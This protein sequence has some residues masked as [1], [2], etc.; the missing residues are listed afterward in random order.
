[1]SITTTT[2]TTAI[3]IALRGRW[4]FG[5][6]NQAGSTP[7]KRELPDIPVMMTIL[8]KLA[9][10]HSTKFSPVTP[11]ATTRLQ[12]Q[13]PPPSPPAATTT[14]QQIG[15]GQFAGHNEGTTN[16]HIFHSIERDAATT[17]AVQ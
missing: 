2:R 12:T 4:H 7:S 8:N 1:M 14:R 6:R 10:V 16:N 5:S 11:S 17:A 13:P 15:T 9:T 3:G